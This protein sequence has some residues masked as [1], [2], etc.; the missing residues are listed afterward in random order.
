MMADQLVNFVAIFLS[1]RTRDLYGV[2]EENV[3]FSARRQ[4]ADAAPDQGCEICL[5]QLCPQRPLQKIVQIAVAQRMD[6]VRQHRCDAACNQRSGG[7]CRKPSRDAL[8]DLHLP[9]LARERFGGE[10]IAFHE[11]SESAAD[12]DPCCWE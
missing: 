3:R 8:P 7:R 6:Q 1:H 4:G 12:F 5:T 2:L 11:A 9:E 10:K